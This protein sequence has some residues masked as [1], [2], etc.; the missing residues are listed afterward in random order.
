[1][2]EPGEPQYLYVSYWSAS[3]QTDGPSFDYTTSREPFGFA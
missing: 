3:E 2:I 1:M